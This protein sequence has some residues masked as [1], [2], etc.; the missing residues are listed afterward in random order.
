MEEQT[1]GVRWWISDSPY[2]SV[3]QNIKECISPLHQSLYK[4]KE[5]VVNMDPNT[6]PKKSARRRKSSAL[7]KNIGFRGLKN[8]NLN[9]LTAKL[10]SIALLDCQENDKKCQNHG[11]PNAKLNN[12]DQNAYITKN[13]N[14]NTH[15]NSSEYADRLSQKTKDT[16]QEI[17]SD[18]GSDR[19]IPLPPLTHR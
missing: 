17:E 14:K 18:K 13:K 9:H 19:T 2:Q 12:I 7:S 5:T 11:I 1:V 8:A 16:Q 6:T 10:N 15:E 3:F 4:P